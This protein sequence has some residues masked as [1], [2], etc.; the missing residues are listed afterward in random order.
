MIA[1][2]LLTEALERGGYY[3]EETELLRELLVL[4]QTVLG[5]N[6]P[7]T[8]RTAQRISANEEFDDMIDEIVTTC[9]TSHTKK[10]KKRK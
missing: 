10:K 1:I 6:H 7:D 5:E 2:E 4:Q 3:D 8:I 9:N